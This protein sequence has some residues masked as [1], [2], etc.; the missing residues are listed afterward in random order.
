MS[1]PASPAVELHLAGVLPLRTSIRV[2]RAWVAPSAL[3]IGAT[4]SSTEA[5]TTT[6]S[7]PHSRWSAMSSAASAK[8][9]G[10]TMP[11]SVS[12]TIA[13]T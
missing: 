12:A 6:A 13:L 11:W 9:S 2:D 8:S 1:T 7:P 3:A 5:D 4:I 10:S